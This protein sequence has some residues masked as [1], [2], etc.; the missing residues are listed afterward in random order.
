MGTTRDD[1]PERASGGWEDRVEH[2]DRVPVEYRAPMLAT[3]SGTSFSESGWMFE[4][5]LDGV[6]ALVVR[7]NEATRL[8]SRTRNTLT[9]TYPEL[10]EALDTQAPAGMVADG[11]IVAFDGEQTSFSL[12]Q[13]RIGLTNPARARATGIPVFLYLFDLLVL[14]GHD[15]TGLPLHE[16][17]QLL[18]GAVDFTD[19][20]RF[21]THRD[22]DGQAYLREAC[23]RG[24]EGLLPNVPTRPTDPAH[25]RATG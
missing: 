23:A 3:Q 21:S 1:S 4:R 22:T 6:R 10:A 20:L 16:R 24:W 2:L 25:A 17:K 11:E 9:T 15:V 7:D 18:E 13:G 12:L 5:K 19:P 14:D 8:Y